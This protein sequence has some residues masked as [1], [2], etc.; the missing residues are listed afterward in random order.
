M[1]RAEAPGT[2]DAVRVRDHL[3]EAA[4]LTQ[5]PVVALGTDHNFSLAVP[6]HSGAR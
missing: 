4:P 1:P 2:R 3:V 5:E 6:S